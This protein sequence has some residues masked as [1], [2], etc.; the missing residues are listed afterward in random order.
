ML[1]VLVFA[2]LSVLGDAVRAKIDQSRLVASSNKSDGLGHSRALEPGAVVWPGFDHGGYAVPQAPGQSCGTAQPWCPGRT[3]LDYQPNQPGFDLN[4][5]KTRSFLLGQRAGWAGYL[6]QDQD[7][8]FHSYLQRHGV[9]PEDADVLLGRA[10]QAVFRGGLFAP[11]ESQ[12]KACKEA[13]LAWT[14]QMHEQGKL[15]NYVASCWTWTYFWQEKPPCHRNATNGL[16]LDVDPWCGSWQDADHHLVIKPASW[17]SYMDGHS[18]FGRKCCC[19]DDGVTCKLKYS[20]TETG[21]D[22]GTLRTKSKNLSDMSK[23]T[24]PEIEPGGLQGAAYSCKQAGSCYE[25]NGSG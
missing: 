3:R 16:V 2:S 24:I 4:A 9:T 14:K 13:A 5:F 8:R 11:F 6:F 18:G 15:Q 7:G 10:N 21:C 25:I 1:K 22:T 20:T 17:N 23:C 12:N 19:K